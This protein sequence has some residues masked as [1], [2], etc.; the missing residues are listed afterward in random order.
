MVLS[1]I[2]KL[3]AP[4]LYF[5]SEPI[6]GT[7][8]LFIQLLER[9]TWMSNKSLNMPETKLSIFPGVVRHVFYAD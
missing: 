3:T 7:P 2:I 6:Q 8:D 9:L 1:S 5:L 4:K